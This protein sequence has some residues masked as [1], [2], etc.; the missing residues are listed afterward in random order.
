MTLE[1]AKEIISEMKLKTP[2]DA[3][4]KL[5]TLALSLG[6]LGAEAEVVYRSRLM[7]L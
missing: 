2:V 6:K 7:E 5:I 1:Q 3:Q 4:K